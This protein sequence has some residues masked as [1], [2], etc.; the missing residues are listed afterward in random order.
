MARA[1]MR[2][3]HDDRRDALPALPH[4]RL[5]PSYACWFDA[6]DR[7]PARVARHRYD[8]TAKRG[9]GRPVLRT[10]QQ[11]VPRLLELIQAVAAVTPPTKVEN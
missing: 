8:L 6:R 1:A 7:A 11:Y 4:R 9:A 10:K 3:A 5:D 2:R